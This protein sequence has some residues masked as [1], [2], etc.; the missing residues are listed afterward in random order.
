MSV[1]GGDELERWVRD[2]VERIRD[3]AESS[4]AQLESTISGDFRRPRHDL[5][6]DGQYLYLSL[7]MPGASRDK[8]DL[9][10]AD[11]EIEVYAEY[12]EPPHPHYRRLTP[13]KETRGYRKTISVGRRLDSSGAEAKYENGLL[14]LRIPLAKMRGESVRIE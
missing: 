9:R 4:I 2:L 14:L 12:M 1:F 8:I 10:V 6:V 13:F 3:T 11:Y 7:E 5:M